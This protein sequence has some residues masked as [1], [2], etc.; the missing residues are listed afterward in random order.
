MIPAIVAKK[1]SHSCYSWSD[2]AALVG[3]IFDARLGTFDA[4]GDVGEGDELLFRPDEGD[5]QIDGLEV[6]ES[7]HL[8]EV[9]K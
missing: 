4:P 6:V 9:A 7:R 8:G 5:I 1:A 2:L 3:K